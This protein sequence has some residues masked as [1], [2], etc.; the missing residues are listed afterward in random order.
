LTALGSVG[1]S[2]SPSRAAAAP[3][4]LQLLAC[5]GTGGTENMVS[6]QVLA[7]H[8]ERVYYEVATLAPAGP[9][10][11]RLGAAGI[12]VHSLDAP[13]WRAHLRELRKLLRERHFDIVNAYGFKA[14]LLA[15]FA[16]HQPFR[17]RRRPVLV[18]GVRGFRTTEVEDPNG[19]KG[20][21]VALVE[22]VTQRMVDFWDANS[23][24]AAAFIR[25]LG[26]PAD[27]VT[28]IPNGLDLTL[29][30]SP[31]EANPAHPPLILCVSRFVARK[32]HVDLV[33][34]LRLLRVA[35]VEFSA[36]LIGDGPTREEIEAKVREAGIEPFVTFRR[37]LDHEPI[38]EL[39]KEASVFCLPSAWEG[40]PGAV[41]EAMAA[42]LAVV[43][44]DVNGTD[45]LIVD[46]VT[47]Y[48]VPPRLPEQLADALRRLLE[49][50]ALQREM[51]QAGRARIEAEFTLETMIDRKEALYAELLRVRA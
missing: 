2:Q 49:A 41:M 42:G 48:L 30:P 29:W 37:T 1:S 27:R 32:R 8:A 31:A 22:R 16:V 25:S 33:E 28:C 20:R 3:R 45:M 10:A 9:I 26:V 7:R 17:R 24:G 47:G 35:G 13:A 12:I 40:M 18:C 21:A 6:A 43:G 4:V 39:M 51:G 34:A 50:P 15:R 36:A 5:D 11:K 23:E 38:R 14:S 44:T 46:G 19:F